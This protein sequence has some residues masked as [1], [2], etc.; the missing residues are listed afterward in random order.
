ML[1]WICQSHRC[2]GRSPGNRSNATEGSKATVRACSLRWQVTSASAVKKGS[3][4]IRCIMSLCIVCD[5]EA[6]RGFEPRSL[7]SG[8]RVL[9]VTPRGHMI[10][11][12]G[13]KPTYVIPACVVKGAF[14]KPGDLHGDGDGGATAQRSKM[15]TAESGPNRCYGTQCN[16]FARANSG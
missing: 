7:D 10:R 9:T 3:C 8:S 1:S 11:L 5:K 2:Q 4:S 14:G 6:S 15:K 12:R 13:S 16:Q